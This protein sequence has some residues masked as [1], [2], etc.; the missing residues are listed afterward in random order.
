MGV[1]SAKGGLSEQ[2]RLSLKS[3]RRIEQYKVGE[4]IILL[5]HRQFIPIDTIKKLQVRAAL[6]PGKGCCGMSLPVYNAV[7]FFCDAPPAKL[8]FENKANAALFCQMLTSAHEGITLEEY[9][10]PYSEGSG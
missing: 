9:V 8:L 7:V 6:L 4:S 1:M 2:Q 10:P 5:P 3:A